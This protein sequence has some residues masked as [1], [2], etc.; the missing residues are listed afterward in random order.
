M[1]QYRIMGSVVDHES[2]RKVPGLRVEAWDKD[3]IFDDLVGSAI[4]DEAGFFQMTFEAAHFE[5]L[6]LDRRPDLF[7]KVYD[8][9]SLIKS[10]EDSVLW[11]MVSDETEIRIEVDA[12]LPP[13]K[14]AEEDSEFS[15]PE[16]LPP[17]FR[18][19]FSAADFD[20]IKQL[21]LTGSQPYSDRELADRRQVIQQQINTVFAEAAE[22]GITEEALFQVE[23]QTRAETHVHFR[24]TGSLGEEGASQTSTSTSK[25]PCC[26]PQQIAAE[27]VRIKAAY[28]AAVARVSK[29]K[30][31]QDWATIVQQAVA[32]VLGPCWIGK[33]IWR[34]KVWPFGR[35]T[36]F[37][38]GDTFIHHAYAICPCTCPSFGGCAE[39]IVLDPYTITGFATFQSADTYPMS[40]WISEG[41]VWRATTNADHDNCSIYKY[42][43]QYYCRRSKSGGLV[44]KGTCKAVRKL[45]MRELAR[46]TGATGAVLQ[47]LYRSCGMTP[48]CC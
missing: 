9:D 14:E 5:E 45:L 19:E 46:Y 7:F 32:P 21:Q 22:Q 33:F 38:D 25:T 16:A 39:C 10:T 20:R 15:I 34:I 17:R 18:D 28:T 35:W 8:G 42:T 31:C 29:W 6:F 48:D 47:R 23:G 13:E 44:Q 30:G 43:M 26:T 12:A 24:D 4:T 11:N 1:E 2:G 3:L 36:P 27:L 40:D 41:N 37:D